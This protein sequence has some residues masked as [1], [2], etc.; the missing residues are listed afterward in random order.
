MLQKH[1]TADGL[2]ICPGNRREP[3]QLLSMY[4]A[5]QPEQA[6]ARPDATSPLRQPREQ[7][8]SIQSPAAARGGART[9]GLQPDLLA[10]QHGS[11]TQP[12]DSP[13]EAWQ[14]MSQQLPGIIGTQASQ[15]C[16]PRLHG[17]QLPTGAPDAWPVSWHAETAAGEQQSNSLPGP[18]GRAGTCAGAG[19]GLG[20]EGRICAAS[21]GSG[22]VLLYSFSCGEPEVDMRVWPPAVSHAGAS[23]DASQSALGSI[24]VTPLCSTQQ[25]A[26]RGPRTADGSKSAEPSADAAPAGFAWRPA[27]IMTTFAYGLPRR[28][29]WPLKAVDG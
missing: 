10:S 18:Q 13:P 1:C 9:A 4:C 23:S 5:A 14:P 25:P 15:A 27:G 24:K 29:C 11:D 20:I 21:M 28:V 17:T 16:P 22:D 7:E 12:A 2:C 26:E 3:P 19:P 6:D 8:A